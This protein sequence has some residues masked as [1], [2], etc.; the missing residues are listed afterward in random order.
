MQSP[1]TPSENFGA[2]RPEPW[3]TGLGR[4]QPCCQTVVR[5]FRRLHG[6]LRLDRSAKAFRS[7]STVHSLKHV[8]GKGCYPNL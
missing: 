4:G 2:A 3:P 6:Q 5:R 7:E 8:P 1:L